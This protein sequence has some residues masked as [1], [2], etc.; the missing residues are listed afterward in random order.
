MT[1][2]IFVT[3]ERAKV[4]GYSRPVWAADDSFVV[5]RADAGRYA[6]YEA[7]AAS[8]TAVLAVVEGQ[9]Q[10]QTA[11]RTGVPPE[12]IVEFPDQDSAAAAVRDGHAD[13]SASTAAGNHAYVRRAGEPGLTAVTDRSPTGRGQLPRAR[14]PPPPPAPSPYLTPSLVPPWGGSPR[15]GGGV[16]QRGDLLLDRR[17]PFRER[18]TSATSDR[19]RGWRPPRTRASHSGT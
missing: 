5:R 13:A 3:G 2:P 15:V 16:H 19:R 14:G 6:S 10:R 4:V 11:L 7:I 9:V 8:P 17:R 18:T 1:T 12:R